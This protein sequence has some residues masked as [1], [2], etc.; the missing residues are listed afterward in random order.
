MHF[1]LPLVYV[2]TLLVLGGTVINKSILFFR[3]LTQE[4]ECMK[5]WTQGLNVLSLPIC[6]LQVYL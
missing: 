4:R 2:S 1:S 6:F 3:N 5:P